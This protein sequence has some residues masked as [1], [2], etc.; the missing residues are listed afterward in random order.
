MERHV[1]HY[2]VLANHQ[3]VALVRIISVNADHKIFDHSDDNED[4]NAAHNII[5]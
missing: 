4:H 3:K 5:S 1:S 2:F